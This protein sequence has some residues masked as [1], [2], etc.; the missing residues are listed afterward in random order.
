[1]TS[2]CI[3]VASLFPILSEIRFFCLDVKLPKEINGPPL[4]L[5]IDSLLFEI[6]VRE[7][8]LLSK[9]F[10]RKTIFL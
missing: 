8:D 9:V 7:L 10:V 5:P 3:G 4:S 1:M 2:D 6:P